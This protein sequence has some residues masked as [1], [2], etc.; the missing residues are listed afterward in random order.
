MHHH[1]QQDKT[2][3]LE[4]RNFE[5]DVTIY[6]VHISQGFSITPYLKCM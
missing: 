5:F 2:G 4:N 1:D 3:C 6:V